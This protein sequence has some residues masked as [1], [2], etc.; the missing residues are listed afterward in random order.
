MD[1]P[2]VSRSYL[3]ILVNLVVL[4]PVWCLYER[5]KSEASSLQYWFWYIIIP[6]SAMLVM[7]VVAEIIVKSPR[8]SQRMKQ[9]TLLLVLLFCAFLCFVHNDT[10][11]LLARGGGRRFHHKSCTGSRI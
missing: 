6:S 7:T 11:S 5:P 2:A 3:A 8:V 4:A 10:A 1:P 9:V